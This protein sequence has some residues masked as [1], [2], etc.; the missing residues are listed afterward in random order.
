MARS[1]LIAFKLDDAGFEKVEENAKKLGTTKSGYIRALCEMDLDE[2]G[3]TNIMKLKEQ[4]EL[5]DEL[6]NKIVM[7]LC[8][9]FPDKS[10]EELKA[11]ILTEDKNKKAPKTSTA[12]TR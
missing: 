6:I 7:A 12:V 5:K 2:A 9:L 10:R 4:L 1:R 11:M 3:I 8:N